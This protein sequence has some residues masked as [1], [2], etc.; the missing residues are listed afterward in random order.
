MKQRIDSFEDQIQGFTPIVLLN[1]NL[2]FGNHAEMTLEQKLKIRLQ[3]L[4]QLEGLELIL[5]EMKKPWF[6]GWEHPAAIGQQL[7]SRGGT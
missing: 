1:Q 7:Y 3:V 6:L 2:L 4:K 5:S